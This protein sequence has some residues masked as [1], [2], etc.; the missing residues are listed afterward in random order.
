MNDFYPILLKP[1]RYKIAENAKP[2]LP[3]MPIKPDIPQLKKRNILHQIFLPTD[4]LIHDKIHYKKELEKFE[5]LMGNYYKKLAKYEEEIELILSQTNISLFRKKEK[6]SSLFIGKQPIESHEDVQKGRYEDNFIG[7]LQKKMFDKI[8]SGL[9]LI[10]GNDNGFF[11]DVAYVNKEKNLCIDI[12]IDEPYSLINK[13]PIHYTGIDN[14]RNNYF[15]SNGWF[16]V[17]F[18]EKQVAMQPKECCNYLLFLIDEI[19]DTKTDKYE[20]FG[21][22]PVADPVWNYETANQYAINDYRNSY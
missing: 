13:I 15:L 18:S 17:R 7:V 20:G 19:L 12:E 2:I 14:N 9:K 22:F 1:H 16:V 5:L 8:H 6:V 21:R 3:S 11:P 4:D 10:A